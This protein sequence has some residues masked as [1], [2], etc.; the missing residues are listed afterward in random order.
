VV[1]SYGVI[2]EDFS[3]EEAAILLNRKTGEYCRIL[4]FL[5]GAVQSVCLAGRHGAVDVISGY[6][7]A[8]E[9]REHH[10]R[11][12]R[13]ANLFPYPNRVAGGRYL[14][15]GKQFQL[16]VNFK[17][18]NNAIHGHVYDQHFEVL[19]TENGDD[20]CS[21]FLGFQH[22]GSFAGFPFSYS[23]TI[24][25]CLSESD[26]LSC[27]TDVENTSQQ[28]M[29]MGHGWHPYFSFGAD[30][31]DR[32]LLQFPAESIFLLD[33]QMIPTGEKVSYTLFNGLKEIGD[34]LFDDCFSL[35]QV[36]GKDGQDGQ[37]GQVEVIL[38]DSSSGDRLIMTI[39]TGD[40]K[41]NYLQ[42][43]TPTDRRSIAIEPMTCLPD[44]FNNGIGLITLKPGQKTSFS[45]AMSF[46]R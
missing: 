10:G 27:T 22:D 43:Y 3:G 36:G 37:D 45:W 41:Y 4:P 18:E 30:R 6:R 24:H 32:L 39:E 28:V 15:G 35:Q 42:I 23:L 20:S 16:P 46:V 2:R 26:G 33:E 14:F 11:V 38:E 13:G 8:S 21:L 34:E 19:R 9:A 40:E 17:E 29:P 7:S 12:F 1:V 44:S 25:F 5:G 31:I